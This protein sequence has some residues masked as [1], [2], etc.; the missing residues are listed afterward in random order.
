MDNQNKKIILEF[1][2][3]FCSKPYSSKSGKNDHIKKLHKEEKIQMEN[4]IKKRK[5]NKM[6]FGDDVTESDEEAHEKL[7]GKKKYGERCDN[8]FALQ[9]RIDILLDQVETLEED[10]RLLKNHIAER[11]KYYREELRGIR[12]ISKP[13]TS[14]KSL[15]YLD[16][17]LACEKIKANVNKLKSATARSFYEKTWDDFKTDLR[18]NCDFGEEHT[19]YPKDVQDYLI[20]LTKK[21]YEKQIKKTTFYN[22]QKVIIK[23]ASLVFGPDHGVKPIKFNKIKKKLIKDYIL[24]RHELIDFLFY[25]RSKGSKNKDMPELFFFAFMCIRFRLRIKNLCNL[26]MSDINGNELNVFGETCEINGEL[27]EIVVT[28]IKKIY[29]S[30]HGSN[31]FAL[32]HVTLSK[33]KSIHKKIYREL[34]IFFSDRQDIRKEAIKVKCLRISSIK[35]SG[36]EFYK[37][38]EK[39][40][41]DNINNFSIQIKQPSKEEN[42]LIYQQYVERKGEIVK[43]CSWCLL[44]CLRNF[45]NCETCLNVYHTFCYP[46]K[47]CFVCINNGNKVNEH[48][49]TLNSFK[50]I[51]H[52]FICNKPYKDECHCVDIFLKK[53]ILSPDVFGP[54]L[55]TKIMN[56]KDQVDF[57]MKITK[58]GKKCGRAYVTENFC[59]ENAKTK[60]NTYLTPYM[61]LPNDSL[62]KALEIKNYLPPIGISGYIEEFHGYAIYAMEDLPANLYLC[63]YVGEIKL[64]SEVFDDDS[65]FYVKKVGFTLENI[66][67][68]PVLKSN[69]ARYISGSDKQKYRNVKV[70]NI[71]FNGVPGIYLYTS[72]PVGKN[73]FLYYDYDW[74][75]KQIRFNYVK[76][77]DDEKHGIKV[78][79]IKEIDKDIELNI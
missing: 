56:T 16:F 40:L 42:K 35:S 76:Y 33:I 12:N 68:C 71:N 79:K 62:T 6:K 77:Y 31:N 22:K 69:F 43:M 11:E 41:Y 1:K 60:Y 10:K 50:E 26:Q 48:M 70:A 25:L 49:K 3:P 13:D 45:K 18:R 57:I 21:V 14:V 64:D 53:E 55:T 30:L 47:N 52:C 65:S 63:E 27:Y 17:L 38:L 20:K 29:D 37:E 54:V 51:M 66:L 36:E 28:N 73:E 39:T 46:L 8:C 75:K 2:C 34:I 78:K 74:P 32:K 9:D 5:D 19:V 59:S 24:T 44:P 7:L 72:K 23:N 58:I 67:V 61:Q 4:L 15:R